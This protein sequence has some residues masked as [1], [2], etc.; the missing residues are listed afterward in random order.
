LA[1]IDERPRWIAPRSAYIHVPFCAHKCGYCDFASVANAEDQIDDYLVALDLEMARVLG[2]PRGVETI[3]IGG[4]TPT[5]LNS[6]QLDVLLAS[7]NRWLPLSMGGEF[8][9]EANP[10]T[11]DESKIEALVRGGVNRVSLGAQSFEP[12]MLTRLE[13]NHDPASVARAVDLLKARGVENFSLDLIF[14]VPSQTP[15]DWR[16]DLKRL[17]ELAPTHCSTYGLTYEKGT[18]LWRERR[19]GVVVPC[20]EESERTMYL[21]AIDILSNNGFEQYE[22]SNFARRAGEAGHNRCRHNIAYWMNHAYWGFGNGAASYV[23]GVRRLN[24]RELGAYIRRSMSGTPATTQE[25]ALEPEERARET[26]IVQLRRLDGVHRQSFKEQTGLE[27]DD[28]VGDRIRRFVAVG[29]LADDGE[30]VHL[31]RDGLPV[32]D[33]ILGS[34]L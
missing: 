2:K 25:E 19:L 32:A 8:T 16:R 31:T 14:G 28:L 7:I 18:K 34:M 5:Y 21:D 26:I 13:R 9:V 23:A 11:L 6:E 30:K 1:M 15:A 22:I 17:L 33:G 20:D 29:M 10:N 27:L 4:G 12:A 24:T 3:F